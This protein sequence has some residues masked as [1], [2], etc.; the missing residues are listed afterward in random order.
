MFSENTKLIHNLG[1]YEFYDIS[2]YDLKTLDT[3][4]DLVYSRYVIDHVVE[5]QRALQEMSDITRKGGIMCC[6]SS[7]VNIRTAFSYPL[8][9]AR[10]TMHLWFDSLRRLNVYSRE[11]GLRLPGMMR[12]VNLKNISIDLI[13]PTL[14]LDFGQNGMQKDACH[15]VQISLDLTYL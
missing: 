5:Q 15:S 6:E 1:S 10:E 3:K 4:F 11:L 2:I 8:I 12:Q 7:A 9:P 13:Q 14:K